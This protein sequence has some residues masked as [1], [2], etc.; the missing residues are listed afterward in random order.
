M[1]PSFYLTSDNQAELPWAVKG[2]RSLLQ[3]HIMTSCRC[4]E[5]RQYLLF[6]FKDTASHLHTY[7][8]RSLYQMFCSC[9]PMSSPCSEGGQG[10]EHPRCVTAGSSSE[11]HFI[12]PLPALPS[13][14]VHYFSAKG[15]I[16]CMEINL[17]Y[18][19]VLEDVFHFFPPEAR[20][21]VEIP[22]YILSA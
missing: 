2:L 5:L 18:R 7:W 6:L 19:P 3:N 10:T 12:C 4:T 8:H 9:N 14:H 1:L 21:Q 11:W 16:P 20:A 22:F 13:V 17:L 15:S